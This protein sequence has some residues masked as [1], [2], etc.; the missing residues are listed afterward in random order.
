MFYCPTP[1]NSQDFQSEIPKIF[2]QKFP[3]FSILKP[4][5]L[6]FFLLNHIIYTLNSKL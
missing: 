3:K 2:N 1:Q 6:D 5:Y 4:F